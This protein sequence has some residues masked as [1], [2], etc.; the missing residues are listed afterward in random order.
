[1]SLGDNGIVT[2]NVSRSDCMKSGII[3]EILRTGFMPRGVGFLT[4]A[5]RIDKDAVV[6]KCFSNSTADQHL[7]EITHG[8]GVKLGLEGWTDTMKEAFAEIMPKLDDLV[9]NKGE[10]TDMTSAAESKEPITVLGID[11]SD[12]P[13]EIAMYVVN[14]SPPSAART[15]AILAMDKVHEHLGVIDGILGDYQVQNVLKTSRAAQSNAPVLHRINELMDLVIAI[16]KDLCS[17][18]RNHIPG[19][20]NMVEGPSSS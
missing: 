15:H 9:A 6:I 5:P 4:V 17:P 14:T 20:G 10:E 13:T 11:L 7:K 12:R 8:A 2:W 3:R 18:E 16:R 19:A 1:M